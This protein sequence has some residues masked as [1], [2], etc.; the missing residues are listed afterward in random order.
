MAT[1]RLPTD[2]SLGRFP[3]P[4][5]SAGVAWDRTPIVHITRRGFLIGGKA[6]LAEDSEDLEHAIARRLHNDRRGRVTITAESSAGMGMIT[7]AARAARRAG[8]SVLE[9]GV[10][11]RVASS[12]PA[13]DVQAT[14]FPGR[15]VFRLEVLPLSLLLF[16][17]QAPLTPT[18]EHPHGMGD[19]PRNAENELAI[20]FSGSALSISSRHGILSSISAS[21]LRATLATLHRYYPED[22]SLILIPDPTATYR[23]LIQIVERLW[24][25]RS[26]D[27]SFGLALSTAGRLPPPEADLHALFKLWERARVVA[28]PDPSPKTRAALLTCYRRSLGAIAP[29]E[30]SPQGTLLLRQHRR[31]FRRAGGTL[32]DTLLRDC[33]VSLF[34]ATPHPHHRAIKITFTLDPE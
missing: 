23:D 1:S 13:G 27:M 26:A 12:S 10:M 8:A 30:T 34:A 11:Q 6:I 4:I 29:G 28:T 25:R 19:D 24:R 7:T 20:R 21:S 22:A 14:I 16:S 33:T 5:S 15:A 17:T 9:L 32:K 2:V 18:R 31:G 3:L